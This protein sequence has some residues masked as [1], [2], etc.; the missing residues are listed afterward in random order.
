MG[1][2]IYDYPDLKCRYLEDN[3][4]DRMAEDMG[5]SRH[6]AQRKRFMEVT[7]KIDQRCPDRGQRSVVNKLYTVQNFRH[8]LSEIK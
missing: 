1:W 6:Y 8:K 2:G 7:R 5:T 3:F 4:A